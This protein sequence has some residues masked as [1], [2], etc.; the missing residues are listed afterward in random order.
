MAA[1]DLQNTVFHFGEADALLGLRNGRGGLKSCPENQGHAVRNAA[2]NAAAV[3]GG[4]DDFSIFHPEGVVALAAHHFRHTEAR[5]ELHALDGWDAVEHLGQLS[6]HAAEHGGAYARGQAG[7]GAFHDAANAVLGCLGLS[8]ALPHFGASGFLQ[9]GE[10]SQHGICFRVNRVK[11]AVP[12][13]ADHGNVGGNTDALARQPLF[14]QPAGDADGGGQP[15]GKM[16]AACRV[17]MSAVFDLGGVVRMAGAGAVLQV[18]VVPG[19]GVGVADE[20]GDGCAAGGVFHQT[21]EKFRRVRLP[22][23][24]GVVVL[25]RGPAGKKGGQGFHIHGKPGGNAVENHADARPVGL[26]ENG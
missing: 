6:L 18:G 9:S 19:A 4:G 15:A 2:Q 5:A 12:D 20:G 8:D 7:D 17:L 23:G 21:G 14:A 11:G 26:A 1:F 10:G 24:G 3:V 16:A 13:S 25:S 22:A